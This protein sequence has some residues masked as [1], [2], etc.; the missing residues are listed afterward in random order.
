L[1][2]ECIRD[3]TC[4]RDNAAWIVTFSVALSLATLVALPGILISLPADYFATPHVERWD[5]S[6]PVKVVSFILRNLV[7]A[8][9][10]IL[11]LAMLVLPGQGILTMI[12][13]L[14]VMEFPGKRSLELWL[15]R[16]KVVLLALNKLRA[17]AGRAP[18]QIR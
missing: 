11:G 12:A 9:L 7:G 2:L 6:H 14:M 16:K 15:V 10:F 4:L 8:V 1:I 3:V 13:A 5:F 18:L 17:R